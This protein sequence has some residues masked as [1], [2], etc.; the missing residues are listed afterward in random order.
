MVSS[1]VKNTITSQP[2]RTEPRSKI[3]ELV[4]VIPKCLICVIKWTPCQDRF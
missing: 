2:L 4:E 1:H 3:F